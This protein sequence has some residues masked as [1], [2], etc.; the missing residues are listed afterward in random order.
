[1]QRKYKYRA[2]RLDGKGWVYGMPVESVNDRCYMIVGATEDAVNT[3]NEVDFMYIE[4][5]PETV[6]PYIG[7]K[8]VNGLE[9]YSKDIIECLASDGTTI[10]HYVDFCE[11]KGYYAQYL[12]EYGKCPYEAGP[13]TQSYIDE[14][15][16]HVA[17]NMFDN[18]ELLK[19]E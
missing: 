17:G 5:D 14:F 7:K 6:C 2:K 9:I 12:I 11:E 18:K 8:D 1:M 4:V 10:R 16:K 19:T 13:V 15:G 3:R